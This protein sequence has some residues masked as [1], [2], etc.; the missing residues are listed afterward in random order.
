MS[1]SSLIRPQ[2][3][4]DTPKV[5]SVRPRA[6][7]SPTGQ[8]VMV[9]AFDL[10]LESVLLLKKPE[11]HK[12]PL[13]AG[14]WTAPGGHVE[15]G[16]L[17]MEAAAREFEEETGILI[18]ADELTGVLAFWCNCDPT[19]RHHTV[20]VYAIKLNEE[21]L[22]DYLGSDDEPLDRFNVS[23]LGLTRDEFMWTTGPLVSMCIERLKQPLA[24]TEGQ[25]A[26]DQAKKSTKGKEG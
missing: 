13:F 5:E 12:N 22:D 17:W 19:E 16:E 21:V 14:K 9:F 7:I 4:S 6:A 20:A 2:S 23:W 25:S 15:I 24:R 1:A 10:D 18:S 26:K 11:T 3:E 8:Y